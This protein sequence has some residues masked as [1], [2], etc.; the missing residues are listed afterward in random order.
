ML[1]LLFLAVILINIKPFNLSAYYINDRALN[2]SIIQKQTAMHSMNESM[3]SLRYLASINNIDAMNLLAQRYEIQKSYL[4]AEKLYL[5]IIVQTKNKNAKKIARKNL[6]TFYKKNQLWKKID[7]F[8]NEDDPKDWTYLSQ[9]HNS[10]LLTALAQ[11]DVIDLTQKNILTVGVDFVSSVKQ[12]DVDNMCK[13][14]IVPVARSYSSLTQ[15]IKQIYSFSKHPF[16]SGLPICF[17]KPLYI[18]KSKLPCLENVNSAI[19]CDFTQLAQISDWPDNIRHLMVIA[20]GGKANVHQG[21]MYLANE[22]GF[23]VFK[24]EFMHL[25][26]FDD[27]YEI[28]KSKQKKR[29]NLNALNLRYSQLT[30]KRNTEVRFKNLKPVASCNG[31]K[32]KAYKPVN[33]LTLMQYLDKGLPKKYQI[34]LTKNINKY[35]SM[36]PVFAMNFAQSTKTRFWYLYAAKLGFKGALIQVALLKEAEGN[37]TTAIKLLEQSGDWPLAQS[38]LARLYYEQM[39]YKKAR[40]YFLLAS[41]KSLDSFAQ[42]FYGKMLFNGQGGKTD[43]EAAMHYFKLSAAQNN[44]LAMNYLNSTPVL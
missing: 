24:H 23:N 6:F 9:L 4:L 28:S 31:S 21:V 8:L 16:L 2:T 30:L 32:I 7:Y 15:S 22:S 26:G 11:E 3:S 20:E 29:C 44:P 17:T 27:E 10:Q 18:N 33:E 19:K 42:Y 35:L 34:K 1:R 25:F 38:N 39:Q 37:I 36:F 13:V 5:K 40:K 43:K 41:T 14:N 12:L